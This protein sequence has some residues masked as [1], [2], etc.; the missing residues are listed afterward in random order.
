MWQY[1]SLIILA[2]SCTHPR[3]NLYRSTLANTNIERIP[4]HFRGESSS[5]I[6]TT[7]ALLVSLKG[8]PCTLRVLSNDTVFQIEKRSV[9]ITLFA[10]SRDRLCWVVL[11]DIYTAC[12]VWYIQLV[13]TVYNIIKPVWYT[14]Q[15]YASNRA[16]VPDYQNRKEYWYFLLKVVLPLGKAGSGITGAWKSSPIRVMCRHWLCECKQ[17]RR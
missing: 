11:F 14:T 5:F 2:S 13:S 7:E 12:V 9:R 10:P 3:Y 8:G 4:K 1:I 15:L 17:Q 6:N 16:Q